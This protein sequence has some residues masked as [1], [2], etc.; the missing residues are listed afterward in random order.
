LLEPNEPENPVNR[1][2]SIVVMNKRTERAISQENGSLLT[3]QQRQ[4]TPGAGA[5]IT[6]KPKT[7][8]P[9]P[10]AGEQPHAERDPAPPPSPGDQGT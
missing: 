3:V 1:R 4:A 10:P 5:A 2:I 6:A 9:N 7:G 8:E